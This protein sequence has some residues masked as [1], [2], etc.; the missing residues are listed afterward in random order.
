MQNP[1][2]VLQLFFNDF[3]VSGSILHKER[4]AV[5]M[6]FSRKGVADKT[7]KSKLENSV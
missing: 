5:P 4:V 1:T 2:Y 7:E 3:V 6:L